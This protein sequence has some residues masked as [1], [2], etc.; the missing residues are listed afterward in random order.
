MRD[1]WMGSKWFAGALLLGSLCLGYGTGK[2]FAADVKYDPQL[3]RKELVLRPLILDTVI[4]MRDGANVMLRAGQ[5]D[6]DAIAH[7]IVNTCAM[8]LGL[9]MVSDMGFTTSDAAT[10]L[11]KM[12][13]AAVR[14]APGVRHK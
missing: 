14:E 9:F 6:E 7:W 2:A 8:P 12:A 10:Y 3:A 4:C 11:F 5:R 1:A 13:Q